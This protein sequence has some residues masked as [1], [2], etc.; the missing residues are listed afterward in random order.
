MGREGYLPSLVAISGSW[1]MCS[2]YVQRVSSKTAASVKANS[3]RT[4]TTMMQ[5]RREDSSTPPLGSGWRQCR[6]LLRTVN[7]DRASVLKGRG[8]WLGGGG[9]VCRA[10]KS[11]EYT[12][13]RPQPSLSVP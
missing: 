9:K 13:A 10:I 11:T 6:T 1:R 5:N 2:M 8:P 12:G 3:P 7:C 4:T